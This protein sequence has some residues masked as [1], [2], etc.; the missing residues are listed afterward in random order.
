MDTPALTIPRLIEHIHDVA[1]RA[2]TPDLRYSGET[3]DHL[4]GHLTCLEM[5]ADSAALTLPEEHPP[6]TQAL[7]RAD[8]SIT[9]LRKANA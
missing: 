2:D 8:K 6:L 7:S 4:I 1:D 3:P 5:L 9:Q